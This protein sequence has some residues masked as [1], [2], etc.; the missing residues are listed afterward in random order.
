MKEGEY[1]AV[2]SLL[3]S[4]VVLICAAFGTLTCVSVTQLSFTVVSARSAGRARIRDSRCPTVECRFLP[5]IP[6][7]SLD[8]FI[9]IIIEK[10]SL[11][12]PRSFSDRIRTTRLSSISSSKKTFIF[13]A[14][15]PVRN[16][17]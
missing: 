10:L 13:R 12:G 1:T 3:R 14:E 16:S 7:L 17:V 15:R 9:M 4:K 5:Y 2:R 6:W 11:I 8:M